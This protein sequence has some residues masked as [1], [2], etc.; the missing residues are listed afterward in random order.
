MMEM[1]LLMWEKEFLKEGWTWKAQTTQELEQTITMI[2]ELQ[3]ELEVQ[4]VKARTIL[5]WT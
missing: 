1:S 5:R 4:R 2:Q 3:G